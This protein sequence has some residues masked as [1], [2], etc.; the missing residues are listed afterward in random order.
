MRRANGRLVEAKFLVESWLDQQVTGYVLAQQLII[1][2]ISIQRTDEI[3]A[4]LVGMRDARI[5]LAPKRLGVA[6]PVHPMP[7]P[8]LAKVR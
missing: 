4:V 7:R 5:T 6:N 2:D 3:V 1:G 8:A